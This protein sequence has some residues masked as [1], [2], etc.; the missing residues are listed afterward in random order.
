MK[1]NCE[2]I[3]ELLKS[4]YP[5]NE[6]DDSARKQ[7]DQHLAECSA[8]RSA[9]ENLAAIALVLRN[10]PRVTPPGNLWPRIQAEIGQKHIP[11]VKQVEHIHVRFTHFFAR[12]KAFAFAA[13][14]AL[15]LM[16]VGFHLATN[17]QDDATAPSLAAILGNDEIREPNLNFGS[18]IENYFL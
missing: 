3:L 2:E 15:V 9:K 16:A 11:R 8:C 1:K 13:A 6:L 5:D 14:A 4:D 12:K 7:L 18:A 17:R 10:A